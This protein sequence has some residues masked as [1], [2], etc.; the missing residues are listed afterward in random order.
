MASAVGRHTAKAR[1]GLALL[2]RQRN[3][4][5]SGQRRQR[6]PRVVYAIFPQV[7]DSVVVPWTHALLLSASSAVSKKILRRH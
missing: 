1:T 7:C 4:P 5:P 2:R 3:F 6:G